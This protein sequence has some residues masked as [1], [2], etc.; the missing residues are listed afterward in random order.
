VILPII[1]E[2][3]YGYYATG[4]H[5]NGE[6]WVSPEGQW[7]NVKGIGHHQGWAY[8]A[9]KFLEPIP[10]DNWREEHDRIDNSGDYLVQRGW[11]MI[12]NWNG[13]TMRGYQNMTEAQ[14]KVLLEIF[15]DMKLFRGWT[16][17]KLWLL[18]E[19]A[20]EEAKGD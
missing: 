11:I 3:E 16:V 8:M 17:R 2:N 13:V 18:K 1:P 5:R 10:E 4:K 9:L 15:G 14:F 7:Y 19:E 6:C 20:K 12:Q